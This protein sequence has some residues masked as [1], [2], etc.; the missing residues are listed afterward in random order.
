ME[1][2]DASPA[3]G[4]GVFPAPR[5]RQSDDEIS[6]MLGGNGAIFLFDCGDG[7]YTDTA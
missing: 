7:G 6:M 5:N 1:T 2:D 4:R 3:C